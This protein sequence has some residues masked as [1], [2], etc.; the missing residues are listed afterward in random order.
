M[1]LHGSKTT[2]AEFEKQI[3][4]LYS[5]P[6]MSNTDRDA[7]EINLT[8]DHLL[9]I[10]FP[11]ERRQPVID[12]IQHV[13]NKPRSSFITMFGLAIFMFTMRRRMRKQLSTVLSKQEVAAY[14]G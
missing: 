4:A 2:K 1:N 14:L 7:A 11:I 12:A 5:V 3:A 9:G 8:I 10:E 13:R 6:N